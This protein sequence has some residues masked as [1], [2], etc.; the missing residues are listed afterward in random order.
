MRIKV[1]L[2]FGVA[3][4]SN[5]TE[6]KISSINNTGKTITFAQSGYDPI[7]NELILGNSTANQG[8]FS[9][10]AAK[11]TRSSLTYST[12]IDFLDLAPQTSSVNSLLVTDTTTLGHVDNTLFNKQISNVAIMNGKPAVSVVGDNGHIYL[13][14]HNISY[15][16]DTIY[17]YS[18]YLD[19]TTAWT[20]VLVTNY[21][22]SYD[23]ET[24]VTTTT[25]TLV[26]TPTLDVNLATSITSTTKTYM[27]KLLNPP[28]SILKNADVNGASLDD[29]KLITDLNSAPPSQITRLEASSNQIFVAIAANAAASFGKQYSCIRALEVAP[30]NT[31][32]GVSSLDLAAVSKS[33]SNHSGSLGI[34]DLVGD[35]EI[36]DIGDIFWDEELQ[37][38]FVGLDLSSNT[39]YKQGIVVG[40]VEGENIN[41][42]SILPLSL[43]DTTTS[44]TFT[45]IVGAGNHSA[46]DPYE[47]HSRQ[48]RTMH[49]TTGKTYLITQVDRAPLDI[50]NRS[51]KVFA[52]PIV[53]T[54][55][56]ASKI[57]T[58]SVNRS[59]LGLSTNNTYTIFETSISEVDLLD[60]PTSYLYSGNSVG[61]EM[62]A[63]I[64]GNR[65]LDIAESDQLTDIQILDD[66]VIVSL[67][68]DNPSLSS[69]DTV[70]ERGQMGL[71]ASTALFDENGNISG[72]TKWEPLN[73]VYDSIHSFGIDKTD[74]GF[75][76]LHGPSANKVCYKP[77]GPLA[78]GLIEESMPILNEYLDSPDGRVF[79]IRVHPKGTPSLGAKRWT[80][81]SGY[82]LVIFAKASGGN[83]YGSSKD[84]IIFDQ[85][86]N[87]DLIK[88]GPVYCTEVSKATTGNNGWLFVG[89][90]GGLAVLADNQGVGWNCDTGL[91]STLDLSATTT[92]HHLSGITDPVY[93]LQA[94]GNQLFALTRK[95]LYRIDMNSSKFSNPTFQSQGALN[96]VSIYQANPFEYLLDIS[97]CPCKGHGFLATTDK[98][99]WHN[100]WTSSTTP[101]RSDWTEIPFTGIPHNLV[102]KTLDKS[103]TFSG[104]PVDLPGVIANLYVT[105][106]DYQN[107]ETNIYRYAVEGSLSNGEL[108]IQQVSPINYAAIT[109]GLFS[110]TPHT[111]SGWDTGRLPSRLWPY[112]DG[113]SP[114][115]MEL[116]GD[117]LIWMETTSKE[118][119]V[120]SN[121]PE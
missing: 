105:K 83:P 113:N 112:F 62:A 71:H 102:L 50:A 29:T 96:P 119:G 107:S 111:L 99:C 116:H 88:M 117:R 98:L 46:G 118:L 67:K 84:Y 53:A 17:T 72:W 52:L 81:A 60:T 58:L 12:T 8:E 106:N 75:W 2:V 41:F 54:N 91:T 28:T 103:S 49:T 65:M 23:M 47:I 120:R 82:R 97:S 5:Q 16:I 69:P 90:Y 14:D 64:V 73:T 68:D 100:D 66:T 61:Y 89:G 40:R 33:F 24:T 10:A 63:S 36:E 114:M 30:T 70:Q 38:L 13:V 87:P 3:L 15:T 115:D 104:Q 94:D 1:F 31:T 92:I 32:T 35:A 110:S 59:G 27:D 18:N 19:M 121:W 42:E 77:W 4:S 9:L 56:D 101:S 48:L 79:S 76:S 26:L 39:N 80:A 109:D 85:T 6:S 78:G 22:Y 11:K 21:T 86:K 51:R 7:N 34:Q 57:G 43:L 108:D 74:N 93:K 44:N 20:T 55:T 95:N 25:Q 45:Y 37:R